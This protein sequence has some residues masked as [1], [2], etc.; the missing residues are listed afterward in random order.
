MT[1]YK[2][3][4]VAMG[5][6]LIL[7]LN[8]AYA[9]QTTT[10]TSSGQSQSMPG[11]LGQ[12]TTSGFSQPNT[13]LSPST[14]GGQSQSMPGSLGQP[15]TGGFLQ[16]ATG[17]TGQSQ[18]MQ[19][20][21]IP[22]TATGMPQQGPLRD[23]F[24][25]LPADTQQI[26][27]QEI[28][29][30]RMGQSQTT[31][32]QQPGT[33]QQSTPD[34]AQQK[35]APPTISKL[36]SAQLKVLQHV[37]SKTNGVLT[38]Q[39]IGALR[40]TP[41]FE[42]YSRE[43][44]DQAKELIEKNFIADD[45]S[46][47]SFYDRS[48]KVGKFQEIDLK[49]LPFGYDFFNSA[50]AAAA[51][52]NDVPVPAN[53][54]VGP[55]DEVRILLWGRVNAQLSLIVDRR[56]SITIPSV[57][58]IYVAG[59]T[60]EKMAA[61]LIKQ[62]SEMI[63]AN[64]DVS[65][66]VLKTITV[67]VLGDVKKPGV[68]TIGS[69][70]TVTDA[71]L[72]A[73]GP[74]EIGSMRNIQL[75]RKGSVVAS[76]DLYKMLLKGDKSS[77]FILQ[78]DDVIF[79]PDS[80]PLVGIAGNV[81]RPAI[82][83]LKE[84]HDLQS[85]FDLAGGLIPT[86]YT[87]QIQIERIVRNEKQIIVDIDDKR[88]D[89][90]KS[91][92]LQ[93]ADLVKVFSIV[94]ASA[95]VVYLNG[96]V[97]KPGKYEMKPAM[98]LKHILQS[99]NDLQS[100]PYFEYAVINRTDPSTGETL[101][102]PFHLGRL[103]LQDDPAANL[104]LMPQDSIHVF[105]AWAFKDKPVFS[106][107]GEVRKPGGYDLKKNTRVRDAIL[108]AGGL[109]KDA[110]IKQAEILRHGK[111]R[112]KYEKIYFDLAAAMAGDEREN[113]ELHDEDQIIIHSIREYAFKQTVAIEGDVR[114]AGEYSY[115]EN[116][117]VKDLVFAAGNV[118]ESAYLDDAEITSMNIDQGNAVKLVRKNISLRK[119]MAGDPENNVHLK[120]YDRVFVRKILDWREERYVTVAGEL[121]YPGRYLIE[122]GERLSS[123]IERAGGFTDEA[124]LRGSIFTRDK[125]RERQQQGISEMADRLEKELLATSAVHAATAFS[126]EEVMGQ[127]VQVTQKKQLIDKMRNVKAM[128]RMT[129]R[130]DHV[131]LLKGSEY[132]IELEHGDVLTVP[133]K[134]SVVGVVG[135]VMSQ[136]TYVF[137]EKWGY[138]DYIQ[139]SGGYSQ[140]ADQS[141][142]FILKVDGT[143]RKA[144][145]GMLNWNS[146]KDRT[147][148]S[149]FSEEM[150]YEV[151]PGDV[152]AIP[153]NYERIAW[154][155]ELRDI[156]QILMNTAVAAGV[157]IQ[158]F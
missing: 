74:S 116:M 88:L 6:L 148:M 19:G 137:S 7:F 110:S 100:E 77:D 61:H 92:R 54:I 97:K 104:E 42:V 65:M 16:P 144:H 124:Y 4:S 66:G 95:N 52:R 11:N 40:Q 115:F 33:Q 71:L 81:K 149:A 135:G 17:V 146:K 99:A 69:F 151:E 10:S 1:L 80:G 44:I 112:D 84:K 2:K 105:S 102:I 90:S 13:G 132:D 57:G 68:Y 82:Y 47:H 14:Q 70:G 39:A 9:Q 141:N 26:I 158:L 23:I 30:Q 130:I 72:M 127:T 87:Q 145:R 37:L 75:K 154:M 86:A 32:T 98:K 136:G 45:E 96:H 60:F 157:V 122:K 91:F 103:V 24:N 3:I 133:E 73:G 134:N 89:K 119:A 21:L 28:N 79:V 18:S 121:K 64:I 22:Q 128:G 78:P 76:F 63:G 41:E 12:P 83:E 111:Q 35:E 156:T 62:T 140:Y 117:R 85:L 108:Q 51:M 123:L 113:I 120:P 126:A 55:G 139:M 131:R 150:S 101:L 31:P 49:L 20:S 94:E 138:E 147:E 143:A 36:S 46:R 153:E 34:A 59:L 15:T 38:P 107:A 109:T 106:I 5:L 29:N 53:Y 93:D 129:V 118:L 50:T 152:I 67:F 8:I 155:R 43:N 58:P 48:R 25:S 27:Q 125:V 142:V 56:G 114:K